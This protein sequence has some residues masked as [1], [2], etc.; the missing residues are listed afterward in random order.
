MGKLDLNRQTFGKPVAQTRRTKLWYTLWQLKG[1]VKT[2]SKSRLLSVKALKD[3]I[4]QQTQSDLLKGFE[5]EMRN[6]CNEHI[7]K[8]A[9]S[10]KQSV[11]DQ[12]EEFTERLNEIEKLRGELDNKR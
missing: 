1:T 12:M 10:I 5:E 3:L 11:T 9:D 6:S 7:E 8:T 2:G 4:K